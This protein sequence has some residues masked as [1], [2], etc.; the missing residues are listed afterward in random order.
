MARMAVRWVKP[1][2]NATFNDFLDFFGLLL[3]P[4]IGLCHPHTLMTIMNM[5]NTHK[6]LKDFTKA[7][8]MY[9]QALDGHERSLAKDHEDTKY[10]ARNLAVL[11]WET[12]TSKRWA[13]QNPFGQILFG[14]ENKKILVKLVFLRQTARLFGSIE[15]HGIGLT[16]ARNSKSRP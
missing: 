8:R 13:D 12:Q 6:G 15:S 9:R 4:L 1:G 16:L 14:K 11:L 3:S 5:A 2:L 10:C 7:E